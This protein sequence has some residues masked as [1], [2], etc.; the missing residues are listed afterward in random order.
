MSL[1]SASEALEHVRHIRFRELCLIPLQL[2]R[3]S[4]E[5]NLPKDATMLPLGIHPSD[6]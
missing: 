2:Q 6:L 3:T 4:W 5:R 1:V